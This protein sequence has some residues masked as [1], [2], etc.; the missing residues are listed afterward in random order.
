MEGRSV[1]FHE[2]GD[3]LVGGDHELLDDLMGQVPLCPDDLLGLSLK[4]ED[5]LGLGKIEIDGPP[6]QSLLTK[7]PGERSAIASRE[8]TRALKPRLQLRHPRPPGSLFTSV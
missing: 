2:T 7:P 1:L 8:G 3:R 4:I 5:H 6:L